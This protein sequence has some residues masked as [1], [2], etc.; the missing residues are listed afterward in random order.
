[1]RVSFSNNE[2]GAAT[3]RL[4]VPNGTTVSQLVR[5]NMPHFNGG[6]HQVRVNRE[7]AAPEDIL[8]DGDAVTVLPNK[9]GGGNC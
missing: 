5:R 7:M 8:E 4:E 3:K 2:S 9:V 6:R 1:M